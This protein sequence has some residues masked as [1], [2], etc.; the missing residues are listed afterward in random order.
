M[1]ILGVIGPFQLLLL[2]VIALLVIGLPVYLLVSRAKYKA[3][4]Q[5]LDSQLNSKTDQDHLAKLE[6]LNELRKSGVL[7]EEE[8]TI[9]KKKILNQQ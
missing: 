2:L 5:L 4:S 8:F 9:Q 3:K 7:S 1:F 6:K